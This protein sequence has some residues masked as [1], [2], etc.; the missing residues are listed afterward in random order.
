MLAPSACLHWGWSE[1]LAEHPHQTFNPRDP[2]LRQPQF[3]FYTRIAMLGAWGYSQ[4]LPELPGWVLERL[5]YH[6]RMYQQHV[7]RFVRTA[8]LYR[9]TE[10]PRR[11]GKGDRWAAFQCSLPD[12]TEHLLF[13]FRLTGAET[14]R[15]LHLREL[16]AEQKYSL[17]WLTS[18][19]AEQRLGAEF[20]RDGLSFNDL[21]E[22][23][24]QIILIR[25]E[26]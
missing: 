13:V 14:E 16:R 21:M 9:L 3:D 17:T 18:A 15:V 4:K 8:D 25:Q 2:D 1:W 24:S 26:S 7:K 22:E 11:N 23:D 12:G 19:K 6:N 20:M 5:T 10:Q